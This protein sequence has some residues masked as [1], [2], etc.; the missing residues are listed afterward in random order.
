MFSQEM[1][2][3]A[4]GAGFKSP[5]LK[6]LEALTRHMQDTGESRNTVK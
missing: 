1:D 4:I 3:L 6:A 2:T 5:S